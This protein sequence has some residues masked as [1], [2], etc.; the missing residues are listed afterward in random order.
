MK[1]RFTFLWFHREMLN[2]VTGFVV[3]IA[4]QSKKFVRNKDQL[5]SLWISN[6]IEPSF[7]NPPLSHPPEARYG[8]CLEKEEQKWRYLHDTTMILKMLLRAMFNGC[9]LRTWHQRVDFRGHYQKHFPSLTWHIFHQG[10]FTKNHLRCHGFAT[11]MFTSWLPATRLSPR[12]K[13]IFMFWLLISYHSVVFLTS[14]KIEL[15]DERI[16]SLDE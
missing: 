10:A 12:I 15:R 3:K 13:G 6:P 4:K 7:S 14:K 5:Y 1:L 2:H 8:M 16:G 9:P 11:A